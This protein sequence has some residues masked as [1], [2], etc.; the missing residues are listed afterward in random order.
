VDNRGFLP[1]KS[2]DGSGDSP[3][4]QDFVNMFQGRD[5]PTGYNSSNFTYTDPGANIGQLIQQG[6]LGRQ[7][8]R[9]TLNPSTNFPPAGGSQVDD[10]MDFS[11]C[12]IRFCPAIR[13][14]MTFY[15]AYLAYGS[16]YLI[17]PNVAQS[18]VTGGTTNWF[19]RLDQ[20]PPTLA[21]A[22]EF[23]YNSGIA[24]QGT[25]RNNQFANLPGKG[26]IWY[27]THRWGGGPGQ[28]SF[29]VL[30]P[31]GHVRTAFDKYA[32]NPKTGGNYG[33]GLGYATYNRQYMDTLDVLEVEADGR[34][35]SRA[36]AL[37]GYSWVSVNKM[38][39]YPRHSNATP[40]TDG[41]PWD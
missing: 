19:R 31:D 16:S 8:L 30:F 32:Y 20:I 27:P 18:L 35:P 41:V 37:Q 17:N 13:K 34:D 2:E 40:P 22:C 21:L 11:I 1:E 28:Y 26:P 6:Y 10:V 12:P 5:T 39:Q 25:L 7:K 23:F 3:D 14:D 9:F 24:D 38:F 33:L 4:V 15:D 36:M 29:N